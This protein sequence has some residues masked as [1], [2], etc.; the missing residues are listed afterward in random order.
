MVCGFDVDVDVDVWVVVL[1]EL[2]DELSV[3]DRSPDD[4]ET[5]SL[6]LPPSMKSNSGDRR[7]AGISPMRP[8]RC[9]CMSP[10]S[11]RAAVARKPETIVRLS[12]DVN[13][14][15]LSAGLYAPAARNAV[16]TIGAAM[17]ARTKNPVSAHSERLCR[18]IWSTP[19]TPV[20]TFRV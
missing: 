20:Q 4:D 12:S 9:E 2:V 17:T 1:P 10:A 15:S 8:V 7:L 19:T 6:A 18:S 5:G 14:S 16:S 11:S 13:F 3:D